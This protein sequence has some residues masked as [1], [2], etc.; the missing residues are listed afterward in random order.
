MKKT[1]FIPYLLKRFV[2]RLLYLLIVLTIIF[3][4]FIILHEVAPF[5]YPWC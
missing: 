4:M 5:H 2:S 1:K 3:V